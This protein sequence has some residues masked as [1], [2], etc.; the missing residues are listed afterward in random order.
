[1]EWNN[2]NSLQCLYPLIVPN[3]YR[4]KTTPP[5]PGIKAAPGTH[6]PICPFHHY[7]YSLMCQCC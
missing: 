2:N 7:L 1:M 4:E 3:W 6:P 5:P